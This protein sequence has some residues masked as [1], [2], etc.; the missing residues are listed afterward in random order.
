MAVFWVI[1]IISALIISHELGHFLAAKWAGVKVEEFGL[2][3][4][5]RIWSAF[6][7]RGTLFSLNLI[8][9][10][11]FVRLAGE[12]GQV[13]TQ[14]S[15]KKKTTQSLKKNQAQI[16]KQ[17]LPANKKLELFYNQ[18]VSKRLIIILAG[19]SVNFLIAII[20]LALVYSVK[21]IPTSLTDQARIG[22]VVP[23]S[24]A[25]AANLPIDVNI[26]QVIA[27]QQVTNITSVTDVQTAV[28]ANRGQTITLVVSEA[29]H[30]QEIC[31][32][33]IQRFDV[34]V[35]LESETPA[36]EG[37]L[38]IAF[39]EAYFKFYPAY[40]MPFRGAWFGLK[41]ALVLGWLILQSLAEVMTKLFTQGQ[42][43]ANVAGPVGIVYQAQQGNLITD[44]FWSNVGFAGM[45]SMNLAVMNLLPLPALDGGRALFIL[46]EKV[47]NRQKIQKVE[48]YVNYLGFTFLMLL[49]ILIT[50]Q[51][52]WQIIKAH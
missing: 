41:Q 9:F 18:P 22:L 42:V 36:G 52:V 13:V 50:F 27:N 30:E 45:L 26:R 5:P 20:S 47:I 48:P 12:D 39:Q 19:I 25:A 46:L 17:L 51:D 29:C 7:W 38:G 37:A 15:S 32:E 11:G 10:G 33:A 49:I 16:S 43:P 28:L 31:P 23:G 35:R 3:Y 21:G 24:P 44:D 2:G 6:R 40:Q 1:F 34:Y 14:A 8:P 4:P